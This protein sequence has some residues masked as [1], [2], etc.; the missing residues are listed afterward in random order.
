MCLDYVLRETDCARSKVSRLVDVL[1]VNKDASL[2]A[3][4]IR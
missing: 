3:S 4:T 1:L 2:C